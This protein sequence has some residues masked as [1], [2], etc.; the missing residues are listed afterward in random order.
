M[1]PPDS[2]Y[3]ARPRPL[4]NFSAPRANLRSRSPQSPTT[5]RGSR[6]PAYL[7]RELGLAEEDADRPTAL[8]PPPANIQCR[9]RDNSVNTGS[10]L[11]A[12][13][14]A[15]G[16]EY[17]IKQID[18]AHLKRHQKEQTALAEKNTLVRLGSAHPGIVRLHWTFQ[19]AWS[20]FFVLDLARN[21]ELQS[22]ISRMGSLSTEC[23][24]YYTAQIVDALDYMHSKGVIHRDLKPENLLLDDAFRIKITD[25]GTGKILDSGGEHTKTFVGT[26]QYVSP[27]LL[28]R[29]ETSKSTDFWALGCIVY[30]MIAGRFVF[31]GLSDWQKIKQLEYTFPEGF[32]EQAK[33][34]VKKLLVRDPAQRL[35]AGPPGSPYDMRTLRAHPFFA[36][37]DWKTLWTRTAPPLEPGLVKKQLPPSRENVS[38]PWDDVVGEGEQHD[39]Q[40]SWASDSDRVAATGNKTNGRI[41]EELIGALDERHPGASPNTGDDEIPNGVVRFATP[42]VEESSVEEEETRD[43]V[44]EMHEVPGLTKARPIDVPHTSARDSYSTGSATSSSD[45]SQPDRMESALESSRGRNRAQT[46]IQ[47]NALCD[48]ELTSLL[49]PGESI[50]FNSFVEACTPKRRA[51]RL[52][53]MAV[54]PRKNKPR[55]LVL[56][57]HRLICVKHKSGHAIQMRTEL[58]VRPAEKEKDARHIISSVEPKGER[59]FVVMTPTKSHCFLAGSPSIASTWIRKIREAVERNS[60]AHPLSNGRT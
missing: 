17:A 48:P 60:S 12:K 10:V 41:E 29:N 27:E 6:P 18:K 22:R 58:F 24:R 47:G 31:R 1:P 13:H 42:P 21:G 59:E 56:T 53:A 45:G 37:I 55:E 54:A 39:D 15:T 14:I 2:S 46:P 19:D 20:L 25:F 38:I 23:A 36:S 11:L 28:E 52:L 7:A 35:G 9:S 34:L 57:T 8:N 30:Q 32:N 26:A 5:P 49:S 43:V 50:I 51:S 33:D 44:N 4:R 40:I 16:K 3:P